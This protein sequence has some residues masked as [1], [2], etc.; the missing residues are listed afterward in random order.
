MSTYLGGHPFLFVFCGNCIG[1][2]SLYFNLRVSNTN[3]TCFDRIFLV[4]SLIIICVN[5]LFIS[6]V[7]FIGSK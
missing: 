3:F 5:L 2:L 4:L 7:Y 1:Y 6:F